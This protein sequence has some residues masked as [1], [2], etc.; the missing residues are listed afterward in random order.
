MMH[1]NTTGVTA[2]TGD[3]ARVFAPGTRSFGTFQNACVH[4]AG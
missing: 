4:I 2:P 1:M 3:A